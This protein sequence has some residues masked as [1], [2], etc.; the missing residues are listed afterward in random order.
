MKNML[1]H[2]LIVEHSSSWA[3]P[4]TLVRKPEGKWRFTV[5]YIDLNNV[6][7]KDKYPLPRIDSIL[8]NI[9]NAKFMT[10]IDLL[11][12]FWQ[13]GTNPEAKDKLAFVTHNGQYSWCVMAMGLSN[14]PGVFQKL[15]NAVL[16][17]LIGRFVYVYIDDVLIMSNSFEEH[18]QHLE[19]VFQR[20]REAKLRLKLTKSKWARH[21]LPFLGFLIA[22]NQIAPCTDKVKAIK[23]A[24]PPTNIKRVREWLGMIGFYRKFIRNFSIIAA[25]LNKLLKKDVPFIWTTECSKSFDELKDSLLKADF[26]ITPNYDKPFILETDASYDGLGAV[27]YQHDAEDQ[28]RPIC[29]TSRTLTP[30]EK[31]YPPIE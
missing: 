7:V 20:L 4:I 13:V 24:Q 25:P 28:L 22:N 23:D 12:G 17:D 6:T 21:K 5:D 8:N 16:R 15:V 14:A 29:F 10:T 19:Q 9:K 30:G 11:S 3:S 1:K 26:L 2:G 27:L 31:K 18:L